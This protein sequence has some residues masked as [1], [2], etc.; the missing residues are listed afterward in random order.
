M[1]QQRQALVFEFLGGPRDG[2]RLRGHI[3]DDTMTEAWTLYRHTDGAALGRHFWCACEYSV[4]ALRTLP[5]QV[6][7][8]LED[9]GYRFRGHIYEIFL[10]W[11]REGY[12]LI[13]AR[14]V[15]SSE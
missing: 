4:R 11:D 10:R 7:E 6:I 12:V 1:L 14:H 9:E 15:G 2:E 3:D 5:W 8:Q 13:R